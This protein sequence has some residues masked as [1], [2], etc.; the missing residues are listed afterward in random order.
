M[1]LETPA[2]RVTDAATAQ[3]NGHF[4]KLGFSLSRLQRVTDTVSASA[5]VNGQ[6][7]SKNL[8]VSEKMELGGMYG[9]RAYPEGEGYGDEGYVVNLEARML[10]PKF[11]EQMPGQLQLIGFVDAGTVSLNKIPGILRCRTAAP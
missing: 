5:V 1:D 8:D 10:L 11:A 2:M 3:T 9:V 7:A 6:V 4:N